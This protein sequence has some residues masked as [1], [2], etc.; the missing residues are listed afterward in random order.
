MKAVIVEIKDKFASVLSDDGCV[1]RVKNNG[2]EVGQVIQMNSSKRMPA[3]K[4]IAF[5][6]S[7]AAVLL[8]SIG[9]WAYASPYSY[10]SL[11]V[12]PSIEYI[13]N[14][15]DRVLRVT[16]VNDDGEEILKE[17]TLNGLKNKTIKQ[18]LANTVEQI[19]EAGY[20]NAPEEGGIIIATSAKNQ[21]KAEELAQALQLTVHDEI[22]QN[23]EEVQIKVISVNPSRVEE[24]Q[25]LGVTPGKLNLVEDLQQYA[26]DPDS[27]ILEE[28]LN[29]PVKDIMKA[30][31][32][33]EKNSKS[34]DIKTKPD[35]NTPYTDDK[36]KRPVE[37]ALENTKDKD[38]TIKDQNK[39]QDKT[40]K[41]QNKVQGKALK[42]QEKAQDKALKE[43]KKA[44]DKNLKE[45]EKAQDKNLKEQN[46]AQDK[47]LK[48]QNKAQDK[49]LKEQNK[50]QGKTS[51]MPDRAEDN[52]ASKAQDLD[53]NGPKEQ[54][55]SKPSG[56]K[57]EGDAANERSTV[58]HSSDKAKASSE[59]SH[60]ETDKDNASDLEI[61][62]NVNN[63]NTGTS[64]R[65]ELSNQTG[66]NNSKDNNNK[67]M[68]EMASDDTADGMA[69]NSG[70]LLAD[71][72]EQS[73]SSEA[74][75]SIVNTGKEETRSSGNNSKGSGQAGN[76]SNK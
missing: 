62:K 7:A 76:N 70:A 10:V 37:Q 56:K 5:T 51:K 65:V 1:I 21:E 39:A 40:L 64:N 49:T 43:Q 23:G 68:A 74:E 8:I 12:N 25:A 60:K 20:F 33:F 46:K 63:L 73:T 75:N 44:Q 31:K 42:E 19:S 52:K 4:L 27:I 41:E 72:A 17:I 57:T 30:S 54:K 3:K 29:K 47:A 28:W 50:A 2:Y 55:H 26:D 24:A 53:D 18:A 14:R 6:A 59:L 48:E 16:P 45:Q 71:S 58:N 38:K 32:E 22:K 61:S 66:G 15:F 35:D 13:V 9:S 36:S 67:K 69:A 11:D 34:A